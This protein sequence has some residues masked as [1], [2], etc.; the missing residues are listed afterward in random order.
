MPD[1]PEHIT[2]HPPEAEPSTLIPQNMEV[3]L[4][5]VKEGELKPPTFMQIYIGTSISLV[6]ITFILGEILLK[7][8]RH[9]LF[10]MFTILS[11]LTVLTI[12]LWAMKKVNHRSEQLREMLNTDR[13]TGLYSS[14]FLMEQLDSLVE[15]EP[16][17]MTMIF[18]DLDELKDYNDKYGHR[19]GDRLIRDSA[20]ALSEAIAGR[21]IGFRY[22][23]DEFIG[24]LVDV[25]RDEAVEMA[26]RVHTCFE[27]RGISASI[28]VYQWYKGLSPD[29]LL[30]QADIAMYMAKN[31]GKGR[32]F[33]GGDENCIT[34]I[35]ETEI[36]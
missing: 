15:Q 26:K 13:T 16:D 29:D 25:P 33:I 34:D 36:I 17:D 7:E 2:T 4:P 23:G 3:P 32:V 28:G 10:I 27:S 30:H 14:T 5:V 1:N 12:G 31:S 18:I 35:I 8:E 20:E 11:I 24:L 19:A 21:G 22:G 9:G 6:V